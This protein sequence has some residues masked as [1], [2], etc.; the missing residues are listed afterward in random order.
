MAEIIITDHAYYR[1]KE[2]LGFNKK[3]ANRMATVAY[4]EGIAHSDT[5][6]SLYSYISSK[7]YDHMINGHCIK[8][9]GEAVYCFK[10]EKVTRK[11]EM[12]VLLLTVWD[13]PNQFKKQ[14]LGLQRRKR[15][16]ISSN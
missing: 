15:Q 4:S 8:I 11:G 12:L 10:N 14:A 6:G 16:E 5:T 9:Y 3:A 13:I 7:S 1:M 2:R